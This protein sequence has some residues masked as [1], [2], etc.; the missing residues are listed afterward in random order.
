M[1]ASGI[2]MLKFCYNSTVFNL[3]NSELAI[4]HGNYNTVFNLPN[5]AKLDALVSFTFKKFIPQLL[6]SWLKIFH[7]SSLSLLACASSK[8]VEIK[9]TQI[10]RTEIIPHS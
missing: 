5:S 7:A 6:S 10:D 1:S 9:Y 2:E 4:E 8:L 3:P